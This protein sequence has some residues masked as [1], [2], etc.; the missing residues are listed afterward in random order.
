MKLLLSIIA[1]LF[2]FQ[3]F[4]QPFSAAIRPWYDAP[5]GE[6]FIVR[7]D[8]FSTLADAKYAA[9]EIFDTVSVILLYSDTAKIPSMFVRWVPDTSRIDSFPNYYGRYVNDSSYDYPHIAYWAKCY[10]VRSI[11]TR[12]SWEDKIDPGIDGPNS[13]REW[14]EYTTVKYMDDKY[15]PL[16]P[17]ICIWMKKQTSHLDKISL[18]SIFVQ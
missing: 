3:C 18:S 9:R 5:H 7:K 1:V 11:I 17:R 16:R 13:Y 2:F 4:S 15:A 12:T 8:T 10:E 14:N 6:R